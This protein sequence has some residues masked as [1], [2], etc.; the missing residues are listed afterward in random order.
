VS[1]RAEGKFDVVG[2]S[3]ALAYFGAL[4]E[5]RLAHGYLF[6]GPGGVGKKTFARRLAQ[7]L[8]CE[9]P[10][11][12]LLGYCGECPSCTSFRAGS[13]PDYYESTSPLKIG[14][15]AER[16]DG[17]MSSRSL[18]REL[19]LRPYSG[20]WSIALLGDV[21]FASADAANALLKLLEEPPPNV[22]VVLTSDAP[23]TLL[24]T[25][26]SRMIEITFGPLSAEEVA[27]VLERE[28]VQ[29]GKA[30]AAAA[31][32][33]GS[34]TRAR[35]FLEG[36]ENGLREASI[37]WFLDAMA[38]RIPDQSFLRLEDRDAS[39]AERRELVAAMLEVVRTVARDWAALALAGSS[40]PLLAADVRERVGAISGR[41]PNSIIAIL[42][43]IAD[44]Q[45]LAETN[46]T[47]GLV[48]DYLRMQLA[49]PTR[50]Q[51]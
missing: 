49:P 47:A 8:L 29:R 9:R 27:F 11:A 23:R 22:L 31:S 43:A 51:S 2:S 24:P 40:A 46:V 13:H 18:I 48:A 4:D 21:E 6:A 36:E 14:R 5:G 34:I 35:A 32:S 39:A 33:L 10:K 28:G 1:V 15:D 50:A 37:A 45:K 20:R 25:I 42:G 38:G 41:S 7:S 17:E 16:E 26:R 44:A 3:Q 30:R 12:T 19:S